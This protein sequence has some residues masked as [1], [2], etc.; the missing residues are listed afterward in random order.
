MLQYALFVSYTDINRQSLVYITT[1][2][3]LLTKIHLGYTTW[4]EIFD[5][6][7]T[8]PYSSITIFYLPTDAQ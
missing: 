1:K 6:S 5:Q 4:V 7:D 3:N 8:R 2:L